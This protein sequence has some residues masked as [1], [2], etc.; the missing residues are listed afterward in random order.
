KE[1]RAAFIGISAGLSPSSFKDFATSPHIYEGIAGYL[2]LTRHK[3]NKKKEIEWGISTSLGV[4]QMNF[5]EH[6]ETSLRYTLSIFYSQ[7]YPL[8]SLGSERWNV[9]AG[10]LINITGNLRFNEAF[11]NNG[12]GF[13]FIPTLFGSAKITRDISRTVGKEV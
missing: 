9:K 4:H 13:E 6:N 11:G 1:E 3:V 12:F 7:L 10:G 2:A 5:N 8:K